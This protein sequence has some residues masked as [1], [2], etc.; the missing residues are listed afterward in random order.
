MGVQ[1]GEGVA[2]GGLDPG[3]LEQVLVGVGGDGV[4][5][6][7]FHALGGQLLVHFPKGCVLAA[8]HRHVFD[9]DFVK[10]ENKRFV[11]F[12]FHL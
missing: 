5:V 1:A 3:L 11:V 9:P 6:G 8:D 10:P 7:H 2:D 4:A 12:V